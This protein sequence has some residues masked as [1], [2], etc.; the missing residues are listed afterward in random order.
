MNSRHAYLAKVNGGARRYPADVAPFMAIDSIESGL[1]I[2]ELALS[3]DRIGILGVIP[4]F[5]PGWEIYKEIEIYQY[6][7][8]KEVPNFNQI[9]KSLVLEKIIFR[10]C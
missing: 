3:G 7:W 2:E 10:Q 9:L 8:E 5:G 1:D 6:I 4:E